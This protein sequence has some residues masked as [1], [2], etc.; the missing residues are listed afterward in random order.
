MD[1]P[2]DVQRVEAEPVDAADGRDGGGYRFGKKP[3]AGADGARGF[4]FSVGGDQTGLKPPVVATWICL[5]AAW[6]FLGSKVPFT[7][8]IGVPLDLVALLLGTICLTRGAV[9][10]G[11]F[12]LFL[13]TV[14]SF[15]VYLIGLFRFLVMGL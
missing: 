9:T 4:A 8:F 5:A 13:G 11:T 12:V 10:T 2:D 14:G 1:N 6:L 15:I 7:I 3:G